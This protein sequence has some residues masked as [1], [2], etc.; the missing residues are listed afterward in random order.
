L[1]KEIGKVLEIFIYFSFQNFLGASFH[2]FYHKVTYS[3]CEISGAEENFKVVLVQY[4][5]F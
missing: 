3:I 4:G 2:F 1:K 5:F